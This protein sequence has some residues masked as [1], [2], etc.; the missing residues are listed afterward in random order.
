[1]SVL[2]WSEAR[3]AI[4]AHRTIILLCAV[5]FL[6]AGALFLPSLNHGFIWY[7]DPIYVSDN[8]HVRTGL[9]WN[10]ITWALTGLYAANWHPVTWWSHM[11]DCELFG[12][13]PWGH[14]LTNVV[15]HG[16]NAVLVFL[17]LRRLTG[18]TWR[19]FVVALLFGVH[20]MQVQSVAWISERKNLLSTMFWMLA[21]WSYAEFAGRQKSSRNVS[22]AASPRPF[23]LLALGF[24]CLGLM[25]KA[26][27][28]TVPFLLLVLDYWPLRRLERKRIP[29]LVAEKLPFFFCAFIAGM[30]TYIAQKHGGAMDAASPLISRIENALIAYCRYLGKLFYPTRLAV[31]YPSVLN[32]PGYMVMLATILLIAISISVLLLRTRRPEFLAGWLWFLGTLVPVIGLIQAGEQSLADRYFYV[33]GIGLFIILIWGFSTLNERLPKTFLAAIILSIAA[34]SLSSVRTLHELAYW[35]DTE[36]LFRHAIAVTDNNY[37]AHDILGVALEKRGLL[38]EAIAQFREALKER[39]NY[40]EARN[41]LGLTLEKAGRTDEALRE[42][43]EAIALRPD[44]PDAHFNLAVALGSSGHVD[45]AEAEYEKV[46]RLDPNAADA[47]NNLGFLF[48]KRGALDQAIFHYRQA[49]RLNPAYARAHFNLGVA[50][51][52]QG[53]LDEAITQFELALKYKPDYKEAQFNLKA[54]LDAKLGAQRP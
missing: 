20:P 13:R 15:L 11:L 12:L 32:W 17:A 35:R 46:L 39:P 45:E 43:R 7:D 34:A 28:I 24:F 19:S 29:A 52:R 37:L 8:P 38:D 50:L 22:A 31:F 44:F 26:M 36:T 6:V 23:Y 4:K 21:L 30:L 54:V 5:L 41:S 18:T 48:D 51:T 25:S 10:N 49:I 33:P 1:M 9:T 2:A 16:I 47:H 53:R 14:H 3:Q 42:Y 27:L 40:P